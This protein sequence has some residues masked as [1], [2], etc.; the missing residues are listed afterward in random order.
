MDLCII[1]SAGNVIIP[2]YQDEV[3]LLHFKSTILDLISNSEIIYFGLGP[4]NTAD[5][6]DELLNEGTF[7]RI[8]ANSEM[9]NINLN[10]TLE[11]ATASFKK[12]IENHSVRWGTVLIEKGFITTEKTIEFIF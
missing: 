3:L 12:L 10:S 1:F 7:F 8:I 6:N 2:D 5:N 9:L 11:A 4:D